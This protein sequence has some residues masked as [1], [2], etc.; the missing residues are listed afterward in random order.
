MKLQTLL[1]AESSDWVLITF[2]IYIIG[3]FFIAGLSNR[4]LKNRNVPV[5]FLLSSGSD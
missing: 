3:V 4:L 1:I 5:G 2:L